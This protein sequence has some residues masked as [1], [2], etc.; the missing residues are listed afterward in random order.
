MAIE[1]KT[2]MADGIYFGL[3]EDTYHAAAGLSASGTCNMQISPADFWMR[4]WMNPDREDTTTQA[5]V[6]GKARHCR[7]LEG[8][9]TFAER[10]CTSLVKADHPTALITVDDLKA[11][12]KSR[13]GD[14]VKLPGKKAALAELVKEFA[15]HPPIWDEM[16][17]RH[18]EANEGKA[19]ISPDVMTAIERQGLIFDRHADVQKLLDGGESEVSI[20]WTD[21]ETGLPMKARLDRLKPTY[22]ADLKT[23]SNPLGKPIRRAILTAVA[24]AKSHIQ[25]H[26]YLT[27]ADKAI[28][29]AAAGQFEIFDGLTVDDGNRIR[30][31]VEELAEAPPG[32]HH[33]IFI[34]YMA[35]GAPIVR[36][37]DFPR[38]LATYDIARITVNMAKQSFADYYETYGESEWVDFEPLDAFEDDEFFR[39]MTD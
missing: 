23:I 17:I 28:E 11:F 6:D 7:C 12:L 31:F 5:M 9:A 3:P 34:F 22:V 21:D 38:N 15:D 18:A 30:G 24:N 35:T 25:T 13:A 19:T 2:Q 10:F 20:F 14:D 4:S 16:K 29:F 32:E 37:I 39:Y 8:P 33:M 27:A 36:P 26:Q 1:F